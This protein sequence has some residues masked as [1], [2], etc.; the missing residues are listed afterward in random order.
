MHHSVSTGIFKNNGHCYHYPIVTQLN[1]RFN[2]RGN[3]FK[4]GR[5]KQLNSTVSN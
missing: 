4:M 1:H 2:S 3:C 5:L